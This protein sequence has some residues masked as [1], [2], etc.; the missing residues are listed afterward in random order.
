[1]KVDLRHVPVYYMN[2]DSHTER[3]R[4]METLLSELGFTNVTRVES[5]LGGP[6]DGLNQTLMSFLP[7]LTPPYLILEDDVSYDVRA[8]LEMDMPD[9]TDLFYVGVSRN[10]GHASQNKDDGWCEVKPYSDTV[11]RVLNMLSAHAIY[12]ATPTGHTLRCQMAE[13]A[14]SKN[15]YNDVHLGRQL[16]TVNTYALIGF[17]PFYQDTAYQPNKYQHVEKYTR[18]EPREYL[19]N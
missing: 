13:Q 3:R 2:L 4:H 5:C 14:L 8:P 15:E 16:Y 10:K 6:V 19:N 18:F 17:P 7:K 1:M 11:C 12:T 9:D